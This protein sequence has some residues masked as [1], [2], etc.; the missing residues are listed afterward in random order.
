MLKEVFCVM[1]VLVSSIIPSDVIYNKVC[2][3]VENTFVVSE[4]GTE[5]TESYAV[6]V[7]GNSETLKDLVVNKSENI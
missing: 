3:L 7:F 6:K 1:A 5:E 4:H 2:D